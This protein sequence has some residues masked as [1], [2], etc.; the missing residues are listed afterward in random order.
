MGVVYGRENVT[1]FLRDNVR[2]AH[3]GQNYNRWRQVQHSLDPALRQYDRGDGF[4]SVI[5]PHTSVQHGDPTVRRYF[6]PD[7]YDP[8]GYA[9]L[10]R[11]GTL[12]S[13]AKFNLPLFT[14]R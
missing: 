8:Q 11:D 9:T 1:V 12:V 14:S 2:F 13:H 10:D 4:S 7:G 5:S 3:D 6:N